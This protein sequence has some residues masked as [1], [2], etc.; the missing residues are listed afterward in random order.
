MGKYRLVTRSDMDGLVAA[1]LLRELDMIDEI[2]FAHPKD[3]QDGK[4]EITGNDIT[5][6]LPYVPTAHLAFDH[7]YSEMLRHAGNEAPN[8][9]NIPT[10]PSAARIV[11]DYFGGKKR[12]PEISEEM[13]REVD[14]ADSAQFTEDDILSEK[15]W[16]LL[17]FIMDP[18]TGLGRYRHF[19]IS[20]YDL[21]MQ[22]I[23]YCRNHTIEE[24]LA[25]P[26]VK[27]R[28]DLYM[29]HREP[30]R[31]Q[32]KRNATVHGPLVVLDLR[33]E[34]Q[35]YCTNRFTIYALHPQ[36]NLSMHVMWGREKQ[37][38]VFA[39]GKSI[40]NRSS[41]L[42]IDALMLSYGGGGHEAAG[43]CQVPVDQA[44]KIKGELIAKMNRS[45]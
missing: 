8:Y 45:R 3:V 21:M 7:H 40:L 11:Y 22:L 16:P 13:M 41:Q 35:I 4:V 1:M 5:A 14:K 23:D 24:I 38:V 43:T 31:E 19:R 32:I 17:S 10:A 20:N 2:V 37:N 42:D 28:V 12:F 36:C 15:G 29:S 34:E 44:E 39:V 33:D 9:I 27:E 18:R 30:A 25:L 26:D 6:N